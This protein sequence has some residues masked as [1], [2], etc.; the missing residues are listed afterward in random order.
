MSRTLHPLKGLNQPIDRVAIVFSLVLAIVIFGLAVFGGRSG[1]KVR[2]FSWQDRQV[3]ADDTAFLLTF[4]RPMDQ[5]SV[6]ENLQITPALPGRVSWAGRRMAYTL[7]APIPYG[8]SFTL[9]LTGARDR[10]TKPSQTNRQLQSFQGAFRSRDR[11]FAYI[12]VE[13]KEAGRLMLY[14]LTQG[15][16]QVLTPPNLLVTDFEA[17][18]DRQHILFSATSR[19]AI[20]KA[21]LEQQLYTVTTGLNLL[22]PA[23]PL[24][25]A[26]SAASQGQPQLAQSP[27]EIQLVLDNKTHRNQ[28]FDLAPDGRT[29]LVK[30][31]KRDNP[32]AEFGIWLIQFDDRAQIKSAPVLLQDKVG[33][34]FLITPDSSAVAIAQ[35]QGLAI[36]PLKPEQEPLD[37]LP[38]FG[39]VINFSR[40]GSQALMVKFNTDYTR[41]LFLVTNQGQQ[42]ELLRIPGSILQAEFSPTQD[43]IYCL[44]TQLLPGKTYREQPFLAVHNLASRKTTPLITLPQQREI[45]LSLAPDGLALLFDQIVQ[46]E[47]ATKKAGAITRSGEVITSSRL[48]VLPI[49]SPDPKIQ[50]TIDPEE[51]PIFGLRPRWLP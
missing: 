37:F 30:R 25:S 4:N 21:L 2:S 28:Q 26:Q 23:D 19:A 33:G 48:W 5:A 24:D 6:A 18:P 3:G 36:L 13:G 49:T 32:G 15:K 45:H 42:T 9:E 17:F 43:N 16:Q 7:D 35:G 31:V 34:E 8:T 27:G 44:L 38:R 39:Q 40:D 46:P 41:S 20:G 29:L 10:F 22:P 12:G 14:N 50:Q 1:P 11:A 47:Q 51:L